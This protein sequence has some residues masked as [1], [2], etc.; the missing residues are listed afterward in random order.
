MDNSQ[1]LSQGEIY[2]SSHYG[3]LRI[4][5]LVVTHAVRALDKLVREH[6]HGVLVT[7]LGRALIDRASLEGSVATEIDAVSGNRKMLRGADGRFVGAW[8]T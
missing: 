6:G 2:F 5:D 3:E 1:D 7:P 4:R 8:S